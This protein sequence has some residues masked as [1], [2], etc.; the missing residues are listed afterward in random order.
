V[1]TFIGNYQTKEA[2]ATAYDLCVL[3]HG[4]ARELLN[5]PTMIHTKENAPKRNKRKPGQKT[6]FI[7]N[8]FHVYL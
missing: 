6:I 4:L 8:Y 5:F 2:A 7:F 3:N 1:H